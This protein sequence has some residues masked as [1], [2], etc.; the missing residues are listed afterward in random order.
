MAQRHE[1]LSKILDIQGP[2]AEKKL[3]QL[4]ESAFKSDDA[5]AAFYAANAQRALLLMRLDAFKYLKEGGKKWIDKFEMRYQE[6]QDTFQKLEQE[7]QDPTRRQLAK[8]AQVTID[9]YRQ[10][11]ISLQAHY[12]KQ[13]QIIETGVFL[14]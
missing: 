1:I 5:I 7:L 2:L 14:S 12:N 3:E 10:G 13:N 9:K 4:R 8:A 6:S 11:F